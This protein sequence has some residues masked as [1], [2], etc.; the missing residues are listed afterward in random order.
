MLMLYIVHM[1]L[2]TRATNNTTTGT[3]TGM[4]ILWPQ[5]IDNCRK[6]PNENG[7]YGQYS[8]DYEDSN[9]GGEPLD[10]GKPNEYCKYREYQVYDNGK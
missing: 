5:Q 9:D 10:H 7:Q 4:Q 1:T 6:N 2:S 3:S 8:K